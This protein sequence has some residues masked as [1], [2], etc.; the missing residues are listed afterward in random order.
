VEQRLRPE[1]S[2]LATRNGGGAFP[3]EIL[4]DLAPLGSASGNRPFGDPRRNVHDYPSL[5][6]KFRLE[7]TS[8]DGPAQ[9]LWIIP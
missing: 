2:A 3:L 4:D 1:M 7:G 8:R 5:P 6:N 9:P